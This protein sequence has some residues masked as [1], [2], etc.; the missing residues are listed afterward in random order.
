MREHLRVFGFERQGIGYA[1]HRTK[2]SR[3]ILRGLP[4]TSLPGGYTVLEDFRLL[5][6]WKRLHFGLTQM[7]RQRECQMLERKARE[8][9]RV[10]GRLS[11]L[12]NT[13]FELFES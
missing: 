5:P 1:C 9:S 6:I 10:L 12:G 7:V 2:A 13:P 11:K 4:A 8:D 3:R